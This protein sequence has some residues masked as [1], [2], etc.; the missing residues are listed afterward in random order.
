MKLNNFDLQKTKLE[1]FY[2]L[3][4]PF[5]KKCKGDSSCL[6]WVKGLSFEAEE[7]WN[8]QVGRRV[9]FSL[10]YRVFFLIDLCSTRSQRRIHL[11]IDMEFCCKL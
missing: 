10:L 3:R 9:T 11:D 8:I 5:L 6:K 7:F 2:I 4:S 1:L